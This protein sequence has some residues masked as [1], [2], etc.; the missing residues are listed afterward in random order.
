MYL[1]CSKVSLTVQL[2]MLSVDN[3][4]PTEATVEGLNQG[5]LTISSDRLPIINYLLNKVTYTTT[6]YH[7][8]AT[9]LGKVL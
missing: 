1:L 7:V 4:M 8:R 3:D 2:G 9:D 6:H 5:N